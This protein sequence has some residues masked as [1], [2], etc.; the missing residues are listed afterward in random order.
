MLRRCL[1]VKNPASG[2][3]D[4]I[5]KKQECTEREIR[6]E[7]TGTLECCDRKTVM[8]ETTQKKDAANHK[9]S[10][11]QRSVSGEEGR[12]PQQPVEVYVGG[13]NE[14]S[15]ESRWGRRNGFQPHAPFY[16]DLGDGCERPC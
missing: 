6:R 4:R 1:V 8:T 2:E 14:E 12:K 13:G 16:F 10:G 3:N 11:S 9:R 15:G 7:G 5:R